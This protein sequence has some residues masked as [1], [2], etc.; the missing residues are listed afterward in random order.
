[1]GSASPSVDLHASLLWTPTARPAAP[2]SVLAPPASKTTLCTWASVCLS[3]APHAAWHCKTLTAQSATHPSATA[4]AAAWGGC[5][6]LGSAEVSCAEAAKTNATIRVI[7][8]NSSDQIGWWL[9][10]LQHTIHFKDAWQRYRCHKERPHHWLYQTPPWAVAILPVPR[11]TTCSGVSKGTSATGSH[12]Q[13]SCPISQVTAVASPQPGQQHALAQHRP[14]R[15]RCAAEPVASLCTRLT[16]GS[17]QLQVTSQRFVLMVCAFCFLEGISHHYV[18]DVT[19]SLSF[20][21]TALRRHLTAVAPT[22]TKWDKWEGQ[23]C[24]NTTHRRY[25]SQLLDLRNGVDSE[26]ACGD[27]PAFLG[28][29]TA[30]SIVDCPKKIITD[31]YGASYII[32]YGEIIVPD[33]SCTPVWDK[34]EGGA[35]MTG[36]LSG[37]RAYTA[38]LHDIP[39]GF[40]WVTTCNQIKLD[41]N[42]GLYKPAGSVADGSNPMA[43][44]S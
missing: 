14:P 42:G 12:L 29:Q 13:P 31:N 4:L 19:S 41:F 39:R 33:S 18:H 3:M 38:K 43:V 1:M 21:G 11:P 44:S 32:Q 26:N 6:Y 5:W 16:T 24:F 10:T 22:E 2:C 20:P 17:S 9:Q 40:D 37:Q 34:L 8:A 15:W 25:K 28:S 23:E 27:T 35:C 36:E 30:V 7:R